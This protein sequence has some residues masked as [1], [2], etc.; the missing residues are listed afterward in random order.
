M[1]LAWRNSP[2]N[3]PGV[4]WSTGGSRASAPRRTISAAE[5]RWPRLMLS[6]AAGRTSG[7]FPARRL[8]VSNTSIPHPWRSKATRSVVCRCC[9]RR[10]P[11]PKLTRAGRQVDQLKAS[12]GWKIA[13]TASSVSPN[14][15]RTTLRLQRRVFAIDLNLPG[16][17]CAS[18]QGLPCFRGAAGR[19]SPCRSD[20]AISPACR[21]GRRW[22]VVKTAASRRRR[23]LV[24][25]QKSARALPIV[26]R[27]PNASQSSATIAENAQ[28]G[29]A[30]PATA[31]N[32]ERKTASALRRSAKLRKVE[33][34]LRDAP[35]S[36]TRLWHMMNCT[37]KLSSTGRCLD[38]HCKT[39]RRRWLAVV[40]SLSHSAGKNAKSSP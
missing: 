25:R 5:A 30:L 17:L 19:Q 18:H 14:N 11:P 32:G 24:A 39:W 15:R 34:G 9:L 29:G 6:E 23:Y 3:A 16:M 10:P 31:T 7:K 37:V 22:C 40:G 38:C 12:Q 35:S 21:R 27:G 2:A 8:T 4:K 26:W 13:G 1:H 28:R 33:S 36:P 20:E